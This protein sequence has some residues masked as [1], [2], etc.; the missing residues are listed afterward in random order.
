[1]KLFFVAQSLFQ[2]TDEE[3]GNPG[4]YKEF[5]ATH[6]IIKSRLQVW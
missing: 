6:Q 4:F 1:M 5:W 3:A 2:Q